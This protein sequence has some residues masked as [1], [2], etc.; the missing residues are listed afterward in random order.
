MTFAIGI[1]RAVEEDLHRFPDVSVQ[2]ERMLLVSRRLVQVGERSQG[3]QGTP[4]ASLTW[5]VKVSKM[6]VVLVSALSICA[7]NS[8]SRMWPWTVLLHL[9]GATCRDGGAPAVHPSV[10]CA[11]VRWL[12][13]GIV[14]DVNRRMR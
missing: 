2:V 13:T 10:E 1:F 9:P 3:L 8:A 6:L 14:D 4:L 11:G 5:T 7:R 12:R